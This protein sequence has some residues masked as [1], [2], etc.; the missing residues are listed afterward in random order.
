MIFDIVKSTIYKPMLTSNY[1]FNKMT[2][3]NEIFYLSTYRYLFCLHLLAGNIA[4]ANALLSEGV[5]GSVVFFNDYCSLHAVF[6]GIFQVRQ[7]S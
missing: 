6:I 2:Y 4:D 7:F 3:S 1:G 5:D